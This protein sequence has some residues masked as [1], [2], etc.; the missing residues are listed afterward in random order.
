MNRFRWL[1]IVAL[2]LGLW[3]FIDRETGHAQAPTPDIDE[4]TQALA[5]LEPY[6]S[7]NT[8]EGVQVFDAK[9]ALSNGFSNGIVFLAEE[10]VAFQNELAIAAQN[11]RAADITQ[12]DVTLDQYPALARLFDSAAQRRSGDNVPLGVDPCGTYS[13]P[14][15]SYTPSWNGFS[16]SNPT[17][18]LLSIGFHHTAP[19]ACG[20]GNCSTSD[21]T[22]G[23]GYSGP[24]GYCSSPRFR[25]HGR[26]WSSTTGGIQYGEPN[27]EI[28]SYSWPYWYWGSYVAWWHSVY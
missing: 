27:P 9:K 24:Y 8:Q 2:L 16:A 15:P 1:L 6:I 22:R 25:D 21:F 18:Y 3:I 26:I 7:Y 11:D 20:Y 4:I 19:Y 14:V 28:H 13:N 10:I 5:A 17:T 12:F 23:R